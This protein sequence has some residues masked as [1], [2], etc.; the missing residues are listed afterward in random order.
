MSN[1]PPEDT[2]VSVKT[3]QFFVSR[4]TPLQPGALGIVGIS[5]DRACPILNAYFHAFKSTSIESLAIGCIV[6][7]HWH[8]ELVTNGEGVHSSEGE[9]SRTQ[10]S[11]ECVVLVRTGIQRWEIHTHGGMAVVQ[12]FLEIFASAGASVVSWDKWLACMQKDT[13]DTTV[14]KQLAQVD[15][16]YEAQILVRQLAG[17]FEKDIKRV[18]QALEATPRCPNQLVLAKSV[19]NRL[20]HA[21]RIGLRL[22][23]PWRV[24]L[25]GPVNAGKSSLVNALAGYDRSIVSRHAGTTRDVLETRVVIDG[26]SVD[27]IDT[28]GL[29]LADNQ[30][31]EIDEIEKK[32]IGRAAVEASNADLIVY[33]QSLDQSVVDG[34]TAAQL[35][36]DLLLGDDL[37]PY[38]SVGTKSD[39]CGNKQLY[40]QSLSKPLVPTSARTGQGIE[41][42]RQVVLETLVPEIKDQPDCFLEGVPVSP[43]DVDVVRKLHQQVEGYSRDL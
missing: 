28:A 5:G 9:C 35:S 2:A 41:H 36:D 37:P 30:K 31:R 43:E 29:H 12:S 19:I 16:S 21:A 26:W 3:G 42:L 4:L 20:E 32:G 33:V 10:E 13:R 38:I 8:H 1:S 22:T 18:Q 24:I 40:G 15:G 25:L 6:V 17:A 27:L 23:K 34:F 39:L 11:Q 7:G 14:R